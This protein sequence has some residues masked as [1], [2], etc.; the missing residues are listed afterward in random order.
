MK[1]LRGYPEITERQIEALYF[2]ET[3]DYLLIN[4]LLWGTDEKTIDIFINLIN[5]DF[6]S[7]AHAVSGFDIVEAHTATFVD[8]PRNFAVASARRT[9][10]PTTI[11]PTT[12][13]CCY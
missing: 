10:P 6:E 8:N 13:C 4:G 5:L 1:K 2:Y 9:K 12:K 11:Y 3:N 7:R